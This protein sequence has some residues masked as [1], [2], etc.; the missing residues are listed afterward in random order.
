MSFPY[1]SFAVDFTPAD[2]WRVLTDLKEWRVWS[3]NILPAH[4]V[5]FLD[6]DVNDRLQLDL[7]IGDGRVRITGE[8]IYVDSQQHQIAWRSMIDGELPNAAIVEIKIIPLSR[9]TSRIDFTYK[10][11][12]DTPGDIE[13]VNGQYH[14]WQE[15]LRSFPA[16]LV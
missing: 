14:L 7:Q 1:I 9:S 12:Q 5:L 10:S 6:P 11:A 13:A 16:R 3:P 4:S 15:L 8:V 2:A